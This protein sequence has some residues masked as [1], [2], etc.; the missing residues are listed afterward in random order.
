MMI[1]TL[2][3][4][5]LVG[6]AWV[7][8]ALAA[9]GVIS[10]A[11][12]A[13]HMFTAGLSRWATLAVSAASLVVAL[14]TAV[15]V[16]AWLATLRRG[17]LRLEGGGL[18]LLGFL[19]IFVAGGL[20]GV[21]VAVLPFD[22]QVHDTY[23]IVAHLHYVLIGG[24]VFP[25][26]AA[27]YH[28]TPLVNGHRLSERVGRWVFG[29]MFVGFNTAFFP[30][31]IAGLLGMPRRVYTYDAGLGWTAS[32][33]VSSIGAFVLALGVA[34]CLVD[35]LRTWCRAQ[36]PHGD[37]WRAGTLEWLTAGAYNT[38]SIPQVDSREPLWTDPALAG[39]VAAG[40]HWLPG[41]VT[42]GRETLVTSMR[43]AVPQ[44]V[45]V[46]PGDS[47]LPF[48]AGL[49]TAGFFL[50]L[51]VGW[52]V[53]AWA[54][55]LAA[56]ASTWRWLWQ[57]DRPPRVPAAEVLAG[58]VLPIGAGARRSHAWWATVILVVVVLTIFASFVFA[59]LHISMQ[60]DVCPPP[61]ASVPH[62]AVAGGVALLWLLSAG[63]IATLLRPRSLQRPAARIVAAW[64][65]AALAWALQGWGLAE[66]GLAPRAD[67]WSA[68][69][70]T[71]FAWQGLHLVVVTLMAAYLLARRRAGLY[72]DTVGRASGDNVALYW[73]AAAA[74]GVLA[75]AIVQWLPGWL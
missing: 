51:T 32:N 42:G 20:T 33:L 28:W 45:L 31:H 34:L 74:Q 22:W 23:F 64:L 16:F 9:V 13:H 24:L 49:G 43:A 38:R 4:T 72:D 29:L 61:G 70:A 15:Q 44:H 71:L 53:L 25:V 50:L 58:V 35:A 62:G 11:L 66:A 60:L 30:M 21:M 41:T 10:F 12:W 52:T 6:Y 19:F 65:A 8:W 36:R 48:A 55:G 59:H 68:T 56:I 1:P 39:E 2:T 3:R 18:F 5:P 75:V 26:F 27:L 54:C 17:R 63:V 69:V 57:A 7:A 46:V 73:L 40:R 67:A 47:W 14:P 37:P